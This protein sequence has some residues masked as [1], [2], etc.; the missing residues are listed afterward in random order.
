[1]MKGEK[2]AEHKCPTCKGT[3]VLPVN[4]RAPE[5]R[6][7]YPARCDRCEGKGWI[8]NVVRSE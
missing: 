6:R 3:G 2:V 1:M 8:A 4:K 5:G 7:I